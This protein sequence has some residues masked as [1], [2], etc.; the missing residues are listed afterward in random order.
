MVSLSPSFF[1]SSSRLP[2]IPWACVI[3]FIYYYCNL[4]S[5]K[6]FLWHSSELV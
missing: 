4:Q 1:W 3:Y 6:H 2:V 5:T